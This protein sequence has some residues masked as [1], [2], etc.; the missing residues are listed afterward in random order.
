MGT[1]TKHNVAVE[2]NI[3]NIDMIKNAASCCSFKTNERPAP[4]THIIT[5]LYT[6]I[7]IYFESFKAGIETCRVSQA[8]KHPNALK[9]NKSY[10]F[11]LKLRLSKI[12]DTIKSPL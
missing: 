2:Q 8:R 6:L 1:K 11:A 9:I 3:I 7:P 4:M 5:T 12:I 10:F